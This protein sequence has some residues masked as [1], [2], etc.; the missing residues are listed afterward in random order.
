MFLYFGLSFTHLSCTN[1]SKQQ[2]HFSHNFRQGSADHLYNISDIL[3]DQAVLDSEEVFFEIQ[4]DQAL[5]DLTPYP[6]LSSKGGYSKEFLSSENLSQL[7]Q[8]RTARRGQKVAVSFAQ[9]NISIDPSISFINKYEILDYKILNDNSSNK[10]IAKLIGKIKSFKGFPDSTYYILPIIEGNYLVLYKL[11]PKDKIPYDELPLAKRVGNLLAVPFLGYPIKYCVAEVIP[12][13]NE[14]KTGQYLPQCEDI[15][16]RAAQ[17]IELKEKDKQIFQYDK[18]LDLFPRDFFSLKE[19]NNNWFYVRTVVKSPDPDDNLVGFT[20]RESAH[21]VEFE[22]SDNTLEV[23]EAYNIDEQDKRGVLFIPVEWVDY[24]IQRD[25]ERL[26]SSFSEEL[27]TDTL[28]EDRRYF[29]IKFNELVE[30]ETEYGGVKTLKNVFITDNYF[31]FNIEITGESQGTFLIRYAFFKKPVNPSYVAKQWFEEDSSQYFPSFHEERRYYES[32]EQHSKEEH[33]QFLR[34]TRFDPKIGEIKWYFSKQTP[35]DQPWVREMGHLAVKLLNKAFEHAGRDS[36]YKIKVVLDNQEDKEV[37]DLRYNILNLILSEGKPKRGVLGLGPH[38]ANP[39]TGEM[40]SATANVWLSKILNIYT[41]HLKNYIRF[42]I[43]QPSWFLQPFSPEVIAELKEKLYKPVCKGNLTCMDLPFQTM[44]V[45]PFYNERIKAL[46]PE[47]TDFIKAHK[48]L[49]YDPENPDLQDKEIIDSCTKKLA[50]LP[51]LGVTLHEMLHGLGQR[52]VFSASVD[53][54]NFYSSYDEI[55]EIFGNLVSNTMKDLFKEDLPYVKGVPF[56]PQPPQ[57][58]SVMDYMNFD[59]PILFVPG[60]LDIAALRFI[61]FDK[62]DGQ[63]GEVLEVPA[64]ADNDSDNPQKSINQTAQEQAKKPKQ[65]RVLC[66]GE[67]PRDKEY[68][69]TNPNKPLCKIFDYG[70]QPLEIVLNNILIF[71]NKYLMNGRN[72]YDSNQTSFKISIKGFIGDL[73]KKYQQK[74]DELL[75]RR[76]KKIEDYAFFNPQHV[77]DYQNIIETTAQEDPDFKSY[78]EIRSP[79]FDYLKRLLFM[80]TKHCIYKGDWEYHAI[81]LDK[82]RDL[83]Q[84][85][86]TLYPEDSREKLINCQSPVV[87][88]KTEYLGEFIAEVGFIYTDNLSYFLRPKENDKNDE[89]SGFRNWSDTKQLMSEF[90]TEPDFGQEYYEEFTDYMLTGT[91]LNPYMDGAKEVVAEEIRVLSYGRDP[92]NGG[93]IGLS[94]IEKAIENLENKHNVQANFGWELRHLKDIDLNSNTHDSLFFK[95]ARQL[96]QAQNRPIDNFIKEHPASLYD[97]YRHLWIVIPWSKDNFPALLFK[98]VN[99]YKNC[100]EIEKQIGIVCP[101]S[102]E[103]RAYVE[104]VEKYYYKATNNKKRNLTFSSSVEYDLYKD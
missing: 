71:N 49:T 95:Q 53:T 73:Y 1:K 58:S 68:T 43:Y 94:L 13:I 8:I 102:T 41:E 70:T 39:I 4:T 47:V 87:K 83:A 66:G 22:P 104:S 56:H 18:K 15:P 38:I 31:S 97:S 63:N 7:I 9:E 30:S 81:S 78:Y 26:N 27:K 100:L 14:R 54:Q 34:L 69:E 96:A 72:R 75:S 89:T 35:R 51:I 103:K 16:L 37:G 29:R 93:M 46:C 64:G 84:A 12:D 19:D 45:S 44:G 59:N 25:S 77:Q 82:I 86:W 40:V 32:E 80:P 76:D 90:I 55:Q 62:V 91:H 11:G 92:W 33:D 48:D 61:Y 23:Q 57:Y 52:H 10:H 101:N 6:P 28:N 21:L 5:K 79:L 65:Y 85:D 50:F 3:G 74:R 88:E 36:D 24:Q 42:E 60:K 99:E 98:K 2:S 17:Y 20:L 67:K